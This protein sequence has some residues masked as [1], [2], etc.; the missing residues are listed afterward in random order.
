MGFLG[1]RARDDFVSAHNSH[2][3]RSIALMEQQR[4]QSLDDPSMVISADKNPLT[5]LSSF[6]SAR[7]ASTASTI[8]NSTTTDR[9]DE[10]RR[11]V[12]TPDYL[13]PESILGIGQDAGIDW[14]AVGVI[15]YEFLYG[16]PPFHAETP[17]Q[18]FENILSRY[19]VFDE[20]IADISDSAKSFID[21]LLCMD[22]KSRLGSAQDAEEIKQHHFFGMINWSTLSAERPKFIP[23]VEAVDDTSYFDSRGMEE[24]LLYD[25]IAKE[26]FEGDS[27]PNDTP[28]ETPS[29]LGT[30]TQSPLIRCASNSS[31]RPAS[32]MGSAASP[33][34]DEPIQRPEFGSF[35]FK[36]LPLLQKAN[37]DALKKLRL[38][39]DQG[40]AA[41]A[42]RVSVSSP[43]SRRPRNLSFSIPDDYRPRALSNLPISP[44]NSMPSPIETV[45]DDAQLVSRP[46][47]ILVSLNEPIPAFKYQILIADSHAERYEQVR[48][49]LL[50]LEHSLD[51]GISVVENGTD[52]V[53][54]ALGDCKFDL[55]IVAADLPVVSG[56]TVCQT[57]RGTDGLNQQTPVVVIIGDE[58]LS[59]IAMSDS[60]DSTL[61][62]D[63]TSEQLLQV[64]TKNG[65]QL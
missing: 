54:T 18:V 4:K 29:E 21:Q 51:I 5:I 49:A 53:T 64:F 31:L 20:D 30:P 1:R 14:W 28:N 8:S 10:D 27:S 62:S 47:N 15:C 22:L 61:P 43:V 6:S 34:S 12:G 17:A 24:R 11:A 44:T 48:Q 41:R 25:V 63:F 59:A 60:I 7:R 36:N 65:L 45:A 57:I 13:S 16:F 32:F 33:L 39:G 26:E 23:Q 55:I 3:R 35:Q 46:H 9:R 56:T 40:A 38:E 52:A 2:P 42:R 19:F 58:D 37:E 50:A